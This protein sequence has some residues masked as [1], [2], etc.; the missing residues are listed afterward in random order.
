MVR[1]RIRDRVFEDK[2]DTKLDKLLEIALNKESFIHGD[3]MQVNIVK[4]ASYHPASSKSTIQGSSRNSR[5]ENKRKR[6]E[7]KKCKYSSCKCNKRNKIG[8]LARVCKKTNCLDM[9]TFKNDNPVFS[10]IKFNELS[11]NMLIH[12]EASVTVVL[13]KCYREKWSNFKLQKTNITLKP[14]CNASVKPI[15]YIESTSLKD[16]KYPLPRP[17]ELFSKLNNGESFTKIDLSNAYNQIELEEES[18]RLLTWNTHKGLYKLNRLPCG[19]TPASAIFQRTLESTLQGLKGCA[20][21]LDNIITT[22]TTRQEHEG[23][24]FKLKL[25]KCAFFQQEIT[26][27]EYTILIEGLK[28]NLDKVKAT[29]EAPIPKNH[30]AQSNQL[31]DM[32]SRHALQQKVNDKKTQDENYLN[33]VVT[34]GLPINCKRIAK[35]T[36]V[37][38]R[39]NKW[40]EIF[41][42]PNITTESTIKKLSETF[43]RWGLPEHIVSDNGPSLVSLQFKK[44]LEQNGINHI[45]SSLFHSATNGAAEN[46]VRSFK[47]GLKAATFKQQGIDPNLIISRYFLNYRSAVH[48]TT[49]ETPVILMLG[50]TLGTCFDLIKPDTILIEAKIVEVKGYRNYLCELKDLKVWKRP[51]NQIRKSCKVKEDK[52]EE[53]TRSALSKLPSS[54]SPYDNGQTDPIQP[55]IP[56]ISAPP[57]IAIH[58]ARNNNTGT[59]TKRNIKIPKQYLD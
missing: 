58:N 4:K 39:V 55:R 59:R 31:A 13:Q 41:R 17:E 20:N 25:T 8:H 29:I 2:E 24:G 48:S 35:E 57:R 15:G 32:L 44:F 9:I 43:S 10:N 40:P 3:R 6:T 21:F 56:R 23:S 26:Y 28:K 34:E 47:K 7:N 49:N 45:T 27:L 19:I 53:K 46:L 22:E 36:R 51:R 30:S 11:L 52:K 12:G 5:Q 37:E 14:F 42:M 33:F 18:T 50:K 16:V 38:Q 1:G 54:Q